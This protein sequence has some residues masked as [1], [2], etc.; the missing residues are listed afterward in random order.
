MP[1][2]KP[3]P[4]PKNDQSKSKPKQNAGKSTKGSF[5]VASILN[6]KK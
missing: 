3:Q 2:K 1:P 6:P 5:D 4:Q